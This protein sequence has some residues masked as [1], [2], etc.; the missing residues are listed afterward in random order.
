MLNLLHHGGVEMKVTVLLIL[1]FPSIVFGNYD[2]YKRNS[3]GSYVLGGC[4]D[5]YKRN[6]NGSYSVGGMYDGYKRNSDG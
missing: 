3:D 4:Y 5:G 1:I 6:P 2:G